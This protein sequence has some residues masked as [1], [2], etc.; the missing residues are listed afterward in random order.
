MVCSCRE[1]L[2]SNKSEQIADVSHNLDMFQGHYVERF[3]TDKKDI[4]LFFYLLVYTWIAYI[5]SIHNHMSSYI[6]ASLVAQR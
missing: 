2:L 6:W 4:D 1:L 5:I 3:K